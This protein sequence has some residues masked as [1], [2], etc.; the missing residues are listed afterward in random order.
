MQYITDNQ[1][2]P[3]ATCEAYVEDD[4][5]SQVQSVLT[6]NDKIE[7][8][9]VAV[10]GTKAIVGVIPYP[11]F[12]RSEREVLER[13]ILKSVYS[14]CDFED[15][16]VSFDTDVIYALSKSDCMSNEDFDA[17][18]ESVQKRRA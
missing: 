10:S 2:K 11:L 15:V 7:F 17:L 1:Y 14:L 6:Q 5:K 13:D 18:F 12:S 3:V 9:N 8:C 16:V 4:V